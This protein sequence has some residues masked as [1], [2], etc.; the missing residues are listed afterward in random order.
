MP[1]PEGNPLLHVQALE[2]RFGGVMALTDYSLEAHEGNVVGIIGPNGAGKT[3]VFN[4][5]SGVVPPSSGSI[6]F[7]N[8]D[9]TGMRPDQR[10]RQGIART[11]Q[12]IRLFH[13][14][15]VLDNVRCAMDMRLGKGFF[16]SV[17]HF[18][19][20]LRS[21]KA[22]IS[23]ATEQLERLG[24]LPVAGE[25]AGNLPYGL[26]RRVEIARAL[27][28]RPRLLLLDEPAAGL[29]SNE[30]AELVDVIQTIHRE[31]PLAVLLVEHDMSVVMKLCQRIQV[32]NQ[33]QVLMEGSPDLVRSDQRVVDA[34]LGVARGSGHA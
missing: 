3:T 2:K 32:L 16:S 11:F 13:G 25:L 31:N 30:S 34:Y 12:N 26:Q 27:A 18:P 19:G 29:N 15:S 4:L 33:G 22:M 9:V 14:L 28:T 20:Y 23:M 24:L 6:I 17:F 7:A 8:Q 5:L 10:A 21:E 1:E